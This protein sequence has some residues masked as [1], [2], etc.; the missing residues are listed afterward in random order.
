MV[1]LVLAR[2]DPFSAQMPA[3]AVERGLSQRR[4]RGQCCGGLGDNRPAGSTQIR[5]EGHH[6]TATTCV[7]TLVLRANHL[8]FQMRKLRCKR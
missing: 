6:A 3:E 1:V 2:E 7:S 4:S 5:E 8:I